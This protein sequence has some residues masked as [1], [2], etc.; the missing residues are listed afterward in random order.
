MTALRARGRRTR[1]V[2][3]FSVLVRIGAWVWV[4]MVQLEGY[5]PDVV[6]KARQ[7]KLCGVD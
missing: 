1:R 2:V 7:T 4:N 3:K 5:A 6:K